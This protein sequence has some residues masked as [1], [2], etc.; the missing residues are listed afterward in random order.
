MVTRVPHI[1]LYN[2]LGIY[3]LS[4][5]CWFW[6]YITSVCQ[7]IVCYPTPNNWI[8]LHS[9]GNDLNGWLVSWSTLIL[10]FFLTFIFVSCVALSVNRTGYHIVNFKPL[11]TIFIVRVFTSLYASRWPLIQ[12][13]KLIPYQNSDLNFLWMA[14]NI[15]FHDF[16]L[17]SVL[18]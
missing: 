8:I 14:G 15:L 12:P 3:V 17:C 1:L 6:V 16:L 18:P 10:F 11:F 9:S 13:W 5:L 2:L 7:N 4:F